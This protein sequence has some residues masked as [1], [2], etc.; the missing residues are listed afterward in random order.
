ML[1]ALTR[2]SDNGSTNN[3]FALLQVNGMDLKYVHFEVYVSGC[4][5]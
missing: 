5:S 3:L 1:N 4:V 2:R